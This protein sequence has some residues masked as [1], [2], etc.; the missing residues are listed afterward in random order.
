MA[1]IGATAGS[2]QTFTITLNSLASA[3]FVASSAVDFSGAT[4]D[5]LDVIVEIAVTPGTVANNKQLRVYLQTSMDGGTN[6]TTGPT[7]G[8]TTT[9]E[10]NL[11]LLG[12]L[13]LNTNATL[14]RTH[15]S[16]MA[17]IGYIPTHA[18]L[19]VLNDSGAALAGSGNAAYWFA[20]KGTA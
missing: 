17:A 3:T 6:Y 18:K 13:P 5:P 15:F 19:V 20:I 14:Q 7:S 1:D 12:T 16:V 2:A 10:P 11:K 9:D 8:T 4:P